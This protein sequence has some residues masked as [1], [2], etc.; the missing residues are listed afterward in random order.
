VAGLKA[1]TTQA[2]LK[3]RTTSHTTRRT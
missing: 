3:V 1:R 2:D